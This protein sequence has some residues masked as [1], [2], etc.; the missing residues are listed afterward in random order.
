MGGKTGKLTLKIRDEYLFSVIDTYVSCAGHNTT[1]LAR[2][3]FEA[4]LGVIDGS[5]LLSSILLVLSKFDRS[6]GI[7]D[8]TWNH[9]RLILKDDE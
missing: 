8:L 9:K 2:L 5:N 6:I 1:P 3:D 4:H 7:T